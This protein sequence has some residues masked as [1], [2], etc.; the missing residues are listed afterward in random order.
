MG[1]CF[2]FTVCTHRQA[3]L[4]EIMF[5]LWTAPDFCLQWQ[6]TYHYTCLSLKI[7]VGILS[8]AAL[9]RNWL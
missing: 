6:I 2:L 9:Q 1:E 3:Q 7:V 5:S 4:S 8:F